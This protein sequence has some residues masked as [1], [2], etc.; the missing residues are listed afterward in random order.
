MAE[1]IYSRIGIVISRASVPA[2]QPGVRAKL[3]HPERVGGSRKSVPV[4]ISPY[5]GV[6]ELGKLLLRLLLCGKDEKKSSDCQNYFFHFIINLLSGTYMLY[7]GYLRI[8][9][10]P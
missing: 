7:L 6:Y 5:K 3:N 2:G 1:T 4:K 8:Y 9:L 10:Q